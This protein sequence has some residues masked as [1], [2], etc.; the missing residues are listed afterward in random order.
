MKRLSAPKNDFGYDAVRIFAMFS[1]IALHFF[2][3]SGFYYL[4]P[5]GMSSIVH[6]TIRTLFY[7]CVPTFVIL[8]GALKRN[9]TFNQKHYIKLI[10]III[11]SLII[12]AVVICYKVF[13]LKQDYP[14]LLWLKTVWTFTQPDYGWYINMYISLF[15]LIPLINAAYHS[16]STQKQKLIAVIICVFVTTFASSINKIRL[17]NGI[18]T[19]IEFVPNYFSGMWPLA[20]YTV[21]L[22][23][24][25]FRPKV[26]KSICALVLLALL[27]A[28]AVIN[29][30]TSTDNFY[31]GINFEN[32]DIVNV[33][34]ASTLF[35]LLYDV[36]IK[37]IPVRWAAAKISSLSVTFYLLSWIGDN[38]FYTKYASQFKGFDNLPQ[39]FFKII[40]LHFII[41][42]AA[43]FILNFIIKFI[44][45]LI[46]KP[47]F[48]LCDK[49]EKS[50]LKEE[51]A[52]IK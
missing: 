23:I 28:Q 7:Q 47:L 4:K 18:F 24:G 34:T 45:G 14:M 39:M 33:I 41:C 42:L 30:S 27:I 35:L 19:G 21:G 12:A 22:Y 49:K 50:E 48:K 52:L 9:A 3:Y 40:P 25:E 17:S 46:T 44:S 38:W 43:S 2:L 5:D 11:N 1:V 37:N 8:T 32:M 16:L 31:T 13:F 10:P 29:Y 51:P 36:K 15:L 26:K 20:Y 6:T